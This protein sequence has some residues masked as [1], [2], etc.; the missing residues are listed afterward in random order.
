MSNWITR[1]LSEAMTKLNDA[2][3]FFKS[4]DNCNAN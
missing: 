4:S 3:V 2:G 1:D